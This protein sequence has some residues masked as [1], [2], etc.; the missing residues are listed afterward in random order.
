MQELSKI[1]STLEP[2]LFV[3]AV[4]GIM[5]L[6]YSIY[7]Q[8]PRGAINIIYG[9]LSLAMLGWLTGTYLA[10]LKFLEGVVLFFHRLSIFFAAPVSASLLLLALTIPSEKLL[11][12][13]RVLLSIIALTILMMLI[14]ISPFA[15]IGTDINASR[16]PIPGPGLAPFG[17]ISTLFSIFAVYFLVKKAVAKES[18][19][20]AQVRTVLAGMLVMLFL[21]IGTILIPITL[22]ES[23][24]FL[25]FVP[26]YVLIFLGT[27]AYAITKYQLFNIKIIVTEALT[28]VIWLVLFAKIFGEESTNAQIIDGL[29]LVF[30]IIFG[31]FLIQSVRKEVEQREYIQILANDLSRAN[32]RLRELDRQKSEFVSIASHQLRSPLTAIRGYASLILEESFGKLPEGAKEAVRRIADSSQQ[33][34]YSV[35]DFLNVSRIEQGRIKFEPVLLDMKESVQKIVHELTPVAAQKGVALTY[36]FDKNTKYLVKAD[37]GK[38]RQVVANLIDNSIKYTPRGS[39]HVGIDKKSDNKVLVSIVDTGVGMSKETLSRLFGKYVRA[40]NASRTNVGGT[41]LGLYVAKSFIE[42]HDGRIW[43]ESKGEGK[44][45]CFFIELKGV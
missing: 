45:S 6:A 44:G 7:R 9:I 3:G 16:S 15:F 26:L 23:G 22:F 35:E 17:I 28:F 41:G 34:V 42:L 27:T 38:I 4:V 19:E 31:Y 2:L 25:P 40:E 30:T 18:I 10:G 32:D 13:K 5:V 43:A 29:V 14:N 37:E 1:T 20:R 12:S 24:V 8:N 39:V 36:D 33:M 11:I 21:V